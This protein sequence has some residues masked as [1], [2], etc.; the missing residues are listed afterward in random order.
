[1]ALSI[2]TIRKNSSD[3]INSLVMELLDINKMIEICNT[4]TND[5]RIQFIHN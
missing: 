1:M 4:S 3:I 5:N 2:L